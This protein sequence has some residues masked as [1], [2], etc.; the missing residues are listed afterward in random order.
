MG[1]LVFK[2]K[3]KPVYYILMCTSDDCS[4]IDLCLR[5]RKFLC[6]LLHFLYISP[7]GPMDKASAS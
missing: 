3:Q 6:S 4:T 1:E 7:C 2:P 5:V